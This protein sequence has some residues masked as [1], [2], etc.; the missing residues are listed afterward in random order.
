MPYDFT[1]NGKTEMISAGIFKEILDKIK[2]LNGL[3]LKGKIL[4]NEE[5][6]KVVLDKFVCDNNVEVLFHSFL[7]KANR[8][9]I[10]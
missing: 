1:L 4:F 3:D 6:L 10:R 9:L 8:E 5:L 2:E 7:F